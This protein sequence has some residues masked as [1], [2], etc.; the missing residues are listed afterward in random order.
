MSQNGECLRNSWAGYRTE[1]FAGTLSHIYVHQKMALRSRDTVE[2][3][4][5]DMFD[6]WCEGCAWKLNTLH[7]DQLQIH[8]TSIIGKTFTT[9]NHSNCSLYSKEE[10]R[11]I[12]LE[13]K[14]QLRGWFLFKDAKIQGTLFTLTLQQVLWVYFPSSACICVVSL[15]SI[16]GATAEMSNLWVKKK[17]K[18]SGRWH[19]N[20]K[21]WNE[22]NGKISLFTC[23][24]LAKGINC[25]LKRVLPEFLC[26]QIKIQTLSWRPNDFIATHVHPE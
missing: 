8:C 12:I 23:Q 2:V 5:L 1:S 22:I 10:R 17:E 26:N 9:C 18:S 19:R 15:P 6:H 7:I 20:P 24:I 13:L 25:S 14:W 21:I 3:S 11:W 16:P 4:I